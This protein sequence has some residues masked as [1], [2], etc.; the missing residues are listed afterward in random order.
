MGGGGGGT[1]RQA[2]LGHHAR[3]SKEE[4][5]NTAVLGVTVLFIN[6]ITMIKIIL[7]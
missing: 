7:Y 2:V 6:I 1:A 5:I 4:I 3:I